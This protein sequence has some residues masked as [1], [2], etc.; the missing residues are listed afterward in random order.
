MIKKVKK[1]VRKVLEKTGSE[2]E[3]LV[4][5]TQFPDNQL[6]LPS[7]PSNETLPDKEVA[8]TLEDDV[9]VDEPPAPEQGEAGQDL[10]PA[11]KPEATFTWGD[12]SWQDP[13]WKNH[14]WGWGWDGWGDQWRQSA[15]LRTPLYKGARYSEQEWEEWRQSQASAHTPTVS[16]ANSPPFSR[17]GT[18]D[19]YSSE[20]TIVLR[21]QLQRSRTTELGGTSLEARLNAVAESEKAKEVPGPSEAKPANPT[22]E[23]P[24]PV[25]EKRQT[26]DVGKGWSEDVGLED[27]LAQ[28]QK[29]LQEKVDAASQ[30]LP[31]T[32]TEA[33][34]EDQK[35][36]KE[37]L[38]KKLSA[39]ARYM[40]YFR[41][42]RSQGLRF[43]CSG[44]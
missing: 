43:D 3:P 21:E 25:E 24:K 17:S 23:L 1:S 7:L 28:E 10:P 36:E 26:D 16:V 30:A 37:A 35:K 6:G 34:K 11:G 19:S 5:Q 4:D 33:E 32:A 14:S 8:P 39:A 22:P 41:A 15:E 29:K 42:V 9:P 27:V 31:S 20:S 44:I 12:G 38:Q 2:S 13:A 40:R 18:A